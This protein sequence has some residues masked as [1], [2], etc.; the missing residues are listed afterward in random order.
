[1]S[2]LAEQISRSVLLP[3][4]L[5]NIALDNLFYDVGS[6]TDE[7]KIALPAVIDRE[8]SI[9]A[10]SPREAGQPIRHYKNACVS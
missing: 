7:E 9:I 1:M 3:V 8:G 4:H 6:L 2:V 10:V 5:R